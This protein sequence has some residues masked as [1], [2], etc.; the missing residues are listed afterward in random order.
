MFKDLI[1]VVRQAG[2]QAALAERISTEP[3]L[4]L[5]L[6]TAPDVALGWFGITAPAAMTPQREI[7]TAWR[8]RTQP[9]SRRAA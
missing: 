5:E 6:R 9:R 2:T 8:F 3:E 4:R 7:P 1:D